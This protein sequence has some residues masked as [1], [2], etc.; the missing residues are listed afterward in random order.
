MFLKGQT[1]ILGW[2]Q[3]HFPNLFWEVYDSHVRHAACRICGY[4]TNQ[5]HPTDQPLFSVYVSSECH[6]S[7]LDAAIE[8]ELE[9]LHYLDDGLKGE[10]VCYESPEPVL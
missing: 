10:Y 3:G 1:E 4:E 9:V 7:F 8:Y 2:L 5:R 6:P